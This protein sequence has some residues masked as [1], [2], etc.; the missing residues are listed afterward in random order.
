VPKRIL[1]FLRQNAIALLALFIALGGASYAAVKVPA[2]SV[3][4]RQL[5]NGS[6]TAKKLAK[7]SVTASKLDPNSIAGHIAEWAQI[8]SDDKVISSSPEG[9]TVT[10]P[11][12]TQFLVS[13]HRAI[14]SSCFAIANPANVV[15][16][17]AASAQTLG[18]AGKGSSTYVI[19]DTFD[20][21]GTRAP[22]SFNVVV[23]CP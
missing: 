17:G 23:I 11:Q 3:G 8:Q 7:Q 12:Q 10:N 15:P 18:T 1:A 13:W 4:T 14:P 6:V 5:R 9:A 20:A 19:V 2:H 16:P 22:E 21:R